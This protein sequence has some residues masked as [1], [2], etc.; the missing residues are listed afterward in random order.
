L[1]GAVQPGSAAAQAG[2]REGDSSLRNA[3]GL[4]EIGNRINLTVQRGSERFRMP[5]QV[6]P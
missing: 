6:R 5:V 4:V 3:V 2:L 1:I